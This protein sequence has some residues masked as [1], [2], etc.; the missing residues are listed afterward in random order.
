[1]TRNAVADSQKQTKYEDVNFIQ[2]VLS[3]DRLMKD[4]F[5]IKKKINFPYFKLH[6]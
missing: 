5:S 3:H 4:M 2:K 6:S 1:M